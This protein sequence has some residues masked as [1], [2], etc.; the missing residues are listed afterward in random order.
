MG[1]T[2]GGKIEV[3]D[4]GEDDETAA[5]ASAGELKLF[6]IDGDDGTV[7]TSE[8]PSANGKFTRDMLD[9]DD[10]YILDSG[11]AIFV[12]IGKTAS[13]SERKEAMVQA[14]KY[15]VDKGRP[16]NIPIERV[17]QGGETAMFKSF[18]EQFDPPMQPSSMKSHKKIK[19]ELGEEDQEEEAPK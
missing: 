13:A 4:P 1:D 17:A 11:S 12:W 7:R 9:G 6:H 18:F 19:E 5:S 14:Q 10:A 3:S 8:V 15:I 16:N 2:L